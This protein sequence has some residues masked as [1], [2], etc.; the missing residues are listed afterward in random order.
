M[1]FSEYKK[2]IIRKFHR[3]NIFHNAYLDHIKTK[4]LIPSEEILSYL[5]DRKNINNVI[6][7]HQTHSKARKIL[8]FLR[9]FSNT[10]AWYGALIVILNLSYFHYSSMQIIHFIKKL[11]I[12]NKMDLTV[13]AQFLRSR[14]G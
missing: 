5:K 11:I 12:K 4:Q 7:N 13:H 3:S 6:I 8:N 1:K 2:R 9:V 14:K 10:K